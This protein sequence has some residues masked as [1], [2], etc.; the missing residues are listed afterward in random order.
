M[1]VL[2]PFAMRSTAVPIVECPAKEAQ[3]SDNVDHLAGLVSFGVT[4]IDIVDKDCLREVEFAS[5]GLLLIW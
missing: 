1:T 5:N 4:R 3:S 2:T